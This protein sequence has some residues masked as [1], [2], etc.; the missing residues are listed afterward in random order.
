MLTFIPVFTTARSAWFNL[1]RLNAPLRAYAQAGSSARS[2]AAPG[3]C[4]L[5]RGRGTAGAVRARPHQGERLELG[6]VGRGG[7]GLAARRVDRIGAHR[8]VVRDLDAGHP[9]RRARV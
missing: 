1:I 9:A 6:V 3:T 4:P 8:V 5:R 7:A 2:G